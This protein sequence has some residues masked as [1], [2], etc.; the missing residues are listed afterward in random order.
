MNL[1]N[2][3]VL[4]RLKDIDM[5]GNPPFTSEDWLVFNKEIQSWVKEAEGCLPK[6]DY[7]N[8][9]VYHYRNMCWTL[10]MLLKTSGMRPSEARALRWN[11]IE[12]ENVPRK[13]ST[14]EEQ[15][16]FFVHV[17]V[18][19]SKTGSMREVTANCAT[20]LLKWK[21]KVDNFYIE[22]GFKCSPRDEKTLIFGDPYRFW[23]DYQYSNISKAWRDVRDRCE[24]NLKGPRLSTRPYTI[25]SLRATRVNELVLAGIDPL[26]IAK[27]LGHSPEM[28][29]RYYERADIR[30]RA[31]EEAVIGAI[32]YGKK[33]RKPQLFSS[34]QI[35]S[36]QT[37]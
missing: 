26:I 2:L 32:P 20:R 35:T 33:R 14:G 16:R 31:V 8:A 18:L 28:M 23:S 7:H 17:R 34:E 13:R 5:Q 15:D 36:K 22:R 24:D 6:C 9:R 19:D 10:W 25:Y 27:Q 30:Q 11:D 4:P 12:F 37:Q 1:S 3:V 29:M 21:E